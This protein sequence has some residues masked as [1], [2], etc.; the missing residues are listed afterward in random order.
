MT[1]SDQGI[2]YSIQQHQATSIAVKENWG[3]LTGDIAEVEN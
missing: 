1:L 3:F 2:V